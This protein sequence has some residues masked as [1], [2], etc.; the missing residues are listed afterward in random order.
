MPRWPSGAWYL[1]PP[2]LRP[3]PPPPAQP[4]PEPRP[5]PRDADDLIY[6]SDIVNGLADAPTRSLCLRR[7]RLSKLLQSASRLPPPPP[8]ETSQGSAGL[9]ASLTKINPSHDSKGTEQV[10]VRNDECVVAP[11]WGGTCTAGKP[12]SWGGSPASHFLLGKRGSIPGSGDADPAPPSS[13]SPPTWQ[14]AGS[15]YPVTAADIS[16]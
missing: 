7:H 9:F 14:Y 1:C 12:F 3:P 15:E 16:S 5:N 6:D 10:Q 13:L 2:G 11:V 8:C 4:P